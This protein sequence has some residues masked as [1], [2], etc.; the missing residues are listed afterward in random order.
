MAEY[1]YID[2]NGIKPLA[3]YM[4]TE[5]LEYIEMYEEAGYSDHK[6]FEALKNRKNTGAEHLFTVIRHM[7]SCAHTHSFREVNEKFKNTRSRIINWFMTMFTHGTL[8]NSRPERYITSMLAALNSSP[9]ILYKAGPM[10]KHAVKHDIDMWLDAMCWLYPRQMH[11]FLLTCA[12]RVARY[13][14]SKKPVEM[15]TELD[16]A[17]L[18]EESPILSDIFSILDQLVCSLR[19][20]DYPAHKRLEGNNVCEATQDIMHSSIKRKSSCSSN[21]EEDGWKRIKLENGD[22]KIRRGSTT[23]SSD[24]F[25]TLSNEGKVQLAGNRVKLIAS[26]GGIIRNNNLH[27][28]LDIRYHLHRLWTCVARFKDLNKMVYP[29]THHK[30]GSTFSEFVVVYDF[31]DTMEEASIEPHIRVSRTR[32]ECSNMQQLVAQYI[33]SSNK[34]ERA[35]IPMWLCIVANS[36]GTHALALVICSSAMPTP[37]KSNSHSLLEYRPFT[38]AEISGAIGTGAIG[39]YPVEVH[40]GLEPWP[41]TATQAGSIPRIAHAVCKSSKKSNCSPVVVSASRYS[42]SERMM[43]SPWCEPRILAME[44][45]M[46]QRGY[47]SLNIIGV[48]PSYTYLANT[49]EKLAKQYCSMEARQGTVSSSPS[50]RDQTIPVL[51]DAGSSTRSNSI[52]SAYSLSPVMVTQT[53]GGEKKIHP[54]DRQFVVL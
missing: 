32:V 50:L 43:L 18:D 39:G 7:Q 35:E 16:N 14:A 17:V 44:A 25:Y 46:R 33:G 4:N 41:W 34:E 47:A 3:I 51:E 6:I 26:V 8:P 29:L 27:T 13:Y 12:L 11:S 54:S 40:G 37:A 22:T 24:M 10:V 53:P 2:T 9:L 45:Y 48:Y 21:S 31:I 38:D 5:E 20:V 30:H 28:A 19:G 23:V 1:I 52:R 42:V 36:D 49:S 15:R